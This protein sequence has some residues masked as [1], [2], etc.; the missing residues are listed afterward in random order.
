MN[1]FLR[2]VLMLLKRPFKRRRGVLE[3]VATALSVWFTDQDVLAHMTNSRYHSL[4]DVGL[5]DWVTRT[6]GLKVLRRMNW[7]PV[8]VHKSIT[9]NRPLRFPQ[10]FSLETQVVGWTDRF[11]FYRCRFIRKG[12]VHAEG[13][14][15]MR[16][17]SRADRRLVAIDTLYEA[18]GEDVERP[19]LP[20]DAAVIAARLEAAA[21]ARAAEREPA[22]PAPG[23]A[24]TI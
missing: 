8:V 15:V 7:A 11:V 16:F 9:F 2:I 23:Q 17:V 13:Y 12:A 3:P 10:R 5:V 19:P 18:M 21:D 24:T 1:H 6:R 22:D 14:T 20:E 4:A